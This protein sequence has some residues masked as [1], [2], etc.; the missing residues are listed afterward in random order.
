MARSVLGL[1]SATDH[2]GTAGFAPE[3]LKG[4]VPSTGAPIPDLHW[5]GKKLATRDERGQ[6]PL[7]NH[8]DKGS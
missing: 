3:Y 6:L 1:T 7:H 5:P 4:K 8:R 2:A